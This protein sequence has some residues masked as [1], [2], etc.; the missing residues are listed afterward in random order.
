MFVSI[1]F[2]VL[3][4]LIYGLT[5]YPNQFQRPIIE[6]LYLGAFIPE[7][8]R[9]GE[10]WRFI[11]ATLLHAHPSHLF[12]NVLGILMFGSLLE[13]AIGP[14]RLLVL[15]AF[16]VVGGLLLSAYFLP[17]PTFGA[18]TIDYGLIG[19]YLSLILLLRFRTDRAAFYRELRSAVVF[20]VIFV[21]WNT[22]ESATVN[23]WAHVGGLLAGILFSIFLLG[24]RNR[25][26][27]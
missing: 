21:A 3:L 5:S 20:V 6:V 25:S 1:G 10:W 14:V 18:S 16:S 24:N 15:Y 23:L 7:L 13:P 9:Q 27:L 22:M 4:V 8:A 17:N 2:S 19:A 11:T 26:A 12:N